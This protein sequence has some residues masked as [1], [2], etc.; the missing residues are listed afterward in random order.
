MA[1]LAVS[2]LAIQALAMAV[3]RS[4]AEAQWRTHAVLTAVSALE[5][6]EL[7]V[8]KRLVAGLDSLAEGEQC[9]SAGRG[10]ILCT[11]IEPR[12]SPPR[13]IVSVRVS[14]SRGSDEQTPYTIATDVFSPAP[15]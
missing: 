12:P 2:I 11:T 9:N 7:E 8:R 5:A 4:V 15:P 3:A 13:Q 10:M 14:V 1:V 6:A